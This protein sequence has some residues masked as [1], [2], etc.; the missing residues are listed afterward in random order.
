M[1]KDKSQL[2]HLLHHEK[3]HEEGNVSVGSSA[4]HDFSDKQEDMDALEA[5]LFEMAKS[6]L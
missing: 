5:K 6:R 4:E 1:D 3:N 2:N